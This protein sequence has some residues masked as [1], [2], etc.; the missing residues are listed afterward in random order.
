MNRHAAFV[1][2]VQTGAL[3][4]ELHGLVVDRMVPRRRAVAV[5]ARAT[6]IPEEAI[7]QDV[8]EAAGAFLDYAFAR[9]AHGEAPEWYAIWRESL[10]VRPSW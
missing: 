1:A 3:V 10:L 4:Q 6:E 8:A 7:P 5:V 9:A 2:I